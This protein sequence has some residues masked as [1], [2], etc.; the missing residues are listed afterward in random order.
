LTS[1]IRKLDQGQL[2]K[3]EVYQH[4]SLWG[5]GR[6]EV[7]L[8]QKHDKFIAELN[9]C[10]SKGE[11]VVWIN[12]AK[13]RENDLSALHQ[14]LELEKAR[15][16]RRGRRRQGFCMPDLCAG[17]AEAQEAIASLRKANRAG[18]Y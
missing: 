14:L 8:L 9:Y 2:D 13:S 12:R 18:T 6:Y 1:L 5:G 3:Q 11:T 17:E 7:E 10:D 16:R 15:L 4:Y